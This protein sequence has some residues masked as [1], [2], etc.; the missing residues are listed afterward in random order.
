MDTNTIPNPTAEELA[1]YTF[2]Q[3]ARAA[4]T[5]GA[6]NYYLRRDALARIY[7]ECAKRGVVLRLL[8]CGEF[9]VGYPA[10]FDAI[11]E[12]LRTVYT[13][14][15]DAYDYGWTKQIGTLDILGREFRI[16]TIPESRADCQFDRYLSGM[17]ATTTAVMAS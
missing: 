3:L 11:T 10:D 9:A 2:D 5:A 6:L 12:P 7:D 15:P 4:S 1:T 13:M 8:S 14:A 17:H 16:V